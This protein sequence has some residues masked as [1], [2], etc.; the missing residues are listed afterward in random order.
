MACFSSALE[1]VVAGDPGV[2]LVGLA[3]AVLP[4]VELAGGDAEP[5]EEARHGDAGLARTSG[6]RNRR[7]RR[8]CRGEPRRPF[9]VPQALFLAGRAPPSA[10]RGPRSCVGACPGGR[11]SCGPW[12]RSSALRRLPVLVEGGGAVLEE[13]LLPEVEEVDGEVVLLAEVGDRASCRG[14]GVGAWRPSAQG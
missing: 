1:P 8:G 2:V 4:G 7:W 10:R 13:L 11:R 6:G 14:G 3:V 5:G 9:R 12:R